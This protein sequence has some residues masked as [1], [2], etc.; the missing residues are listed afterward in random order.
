MCL[1]PMRQ[2]VRLKDSFKPNASQELCSYFS[3]LETAAV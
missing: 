1:A 3:V 2:V